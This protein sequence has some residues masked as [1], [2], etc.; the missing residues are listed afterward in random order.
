M[1]LDLAVQEQA[2]QTNIIKTRIE[3]SLKVQPVQGNRSNSRLY[4]Q[5]VQEDC[6]N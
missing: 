5:F 2:I 4:S 3:K 6:L 1:V